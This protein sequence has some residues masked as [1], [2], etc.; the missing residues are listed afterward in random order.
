MSRCS[1]PVF[2]YHSVAPKRISGWVLN[3]LTF[4]LEKFEDQL[5]YLVNHGF[6]SLFLDEYSD[7]REG[8]KPGQGNEICLTFDDGYLDNWVYVWPLV[9]KY[10]LRFTLFVSPECVDPRSLIRPNL[11][12]VWDGNCNLQ[13]LDDKGYLTWDELRMMQDSG[14]VDIQS[15]TM[16]HTKYVTSGELQGFY[17]GGSRGVYPIW[18][19]NPGLKPDYM[20]DLDFEHRLPW[21]YPLFKEESAVIAH[22]ITINPELYQQLHSL[23]NSKDLEEPAAR[24]EYE[25]KAR[26]ILKNFQ[27]TQNLVI[28]QEPDQQYYQ[29]MHYEVVTS[30]EILEQKLEKPV[31]F[32]C[33]PHGD[34]TQEA[35]ELAR[36]V[37]YR[38]TTSGKLS[39]EATKLDRIPRLGGDFENA[40][41]ISRQKFHFKINSHYQRQPYRT[42]REMYNLKNRLLKRV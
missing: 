37:G 11:E 14:V 41:W 32:L 8:K 26:Q 21:G 34:N 16:S 27:V 23:Q 31:K 40:P 25:I 33:W 15:H 3:G 10:G 5:Q 6:K 35:H 17:Y 22:R 19:L 18:N 12:D 2:Y 36:S 13:D 20:A 42:V 4:S 29:R 24:Q 1:P 9:K 30:K 7:I 28:D 38:A 39:D